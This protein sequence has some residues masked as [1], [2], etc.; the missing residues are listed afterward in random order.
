M[1]T[2]QSPEYIQ[3]LQVAGAASKHKNSLFTSAL[4]AETVRLYSIVPHMYGMVAVTAEPR[5]DYYFHDNLSDAEKD[6]LP[7]GLDSFPYSDDP[8]SVDSVVRQIG[9][10]SLHK[11]NPNALESKNY[12]RVRR[13]VVSF[14]GASVL[15]STF[16]HGINHETIG[17]VLDSVVGANGFS[18]FTNYIL[19]V[20]GQRHNLR[21][22]SE[23]LEAARNKATSVK[24]GAIYLSG[25][26]IAMPAESYK[27]IREKEISTIEG[28]FSPGKAFVALL[29]KSKDPSI[30]WTAGLETKARSISELQMKYKQIQNE[31]QQ[32]Q[33]LGSYT[34][35]ITLDQMARLDIEARSIVNAIVNEYLDAKEITH[36]LDNYGRANDEISELHSLLYELIGVGP[37]EGKPDIYDDN[38]QVFRDVLFSSLLATENINPNILA[39]VNK[40]QSYINGFSG[41]I[42]KI[43][44]LKLFYAGLYNRFGND[45]SLPSWEEVRGRF[46]AE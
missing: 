8:Y 4:I 18:F 21:K 22:R 26:T 29:T 38:L 10:V 12:R 20:L 7:H 6:I 14:V 37:T 1:E 35:T 25:E 19:K 16:V 30:L 17:I 27:I 39:V 43:E 46:V 2:R 24:D 36:T 40:A 32:L 31:K 13:S 9:S 3:A 15:S 5:G 23:D 11:E 44:H 34:K 41:G 33:E 42:A 28:Y 45:F